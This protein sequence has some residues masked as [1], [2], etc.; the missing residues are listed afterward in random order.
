MNRM[1]PI[2]ISAVF[3][4]TSVASGAT[5]EWI[6]SKGVVHFTDDPDRIPAKY[7]KR[8]RERES[9]KGEE[10]KSAPSPE[11][12]SAPSAAGS[13]DTHGQAYGGNDEKRW[14]SRFVGLRTDIKGLEDGLAQK[15]EK[16]IVL[17]RKRT[18]YHRPGDR[19]AVNDLTDEIARDEAR[20][21]E[22]REE[23]DKTEADAVRS[24]VPSGW[25]Q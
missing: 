7:L 3:A 2:L 12:S 22:L 21:K 1:I 23:L 13:M 14:R 18:L 19:V 11:K 8:V 5:Y 9:L 20:I 4:V 17:Q 6:D 15:R 24:G 16:L 10:M 25:R